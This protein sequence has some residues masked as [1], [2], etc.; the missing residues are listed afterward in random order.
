MRVE[1][2]LNTRQGPAVGDAQVP[3]RES[4]CDAVRDAVRAAFGEAYSTEHAVAVRSLCAQM[5]AADLPFTY[6]VPA[7]A[8][9]LEA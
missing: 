6:R 5:R 8:V 1:W 3:D 7:V 4:A 2:M 9:T